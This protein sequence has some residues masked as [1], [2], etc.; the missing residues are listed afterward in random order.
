MNSTDKKNALLIKIE[1]ADNE[2]SLFSGVEKI[3]VGLSG[4][5]D[6]TC[7]LHSL[8]SLSEKYGFTLYALHVN[9]M[10]RGAE[11][12]R[13]EDFARNLCEKL[14]VTFFCERVDVPSLS[15]KT[16][17]S[18]ELCA[19][20]VRY[21]AFEKVCREHNI[22]CVATA[23]NA[24][25][26]AETMLFNLVRG[27]GT[28]GLCG[29][30]P[31][32]EL[33]Y[34]IFVVRPLIFAQR[35]EIEEYLS[36]HGQDFVTDSTN[37]DSDYTRNYLRNEIIP[38]LKKINPSLEESLQ[39]SASLHRMDEMFLSQTAEKSLTDNVDE[40]KK[41]DE[42][43]LSRVIMSMFYNCCKKTAEQKHIKELCRKIYSSDGENTNI[44]FSEGMI[45]KIYKGR[46]SFCRDERVPCRKHTQFS[47][48]LCKGLTAF[49]ETPYALYISFDEK[50][51]ISQ[52]LSFGENV[53]KK[54]TTDYL[55]F[56]TIPCVLYGRNRQDA[57]KI[58]CGRMNKSVKRLMNE[59][60][61]DESERY[62]LPFVCTKEKI[63]LVPGVAVNDDCRKAENKTHKLSVTL[64]RKA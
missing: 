42:S 7:L 11:A 40:L 41:L 43:I 22:N 23:H 51:D 63:L 15:E 32:R 6:S 62:L 8:K 24:C 37:C 57:D 21:S 3:L 39:R 38:K 26:N 13:D 61:L 58:L 16:G 49:E 47:K 5:A 45:A 12:D 1:K 56:D 52:T 27:A 53:Y 28:K 20:N 2:F 36:Y 34:G 18:V 46:L 54:Y 55:Y 10:I 19:R 17:E 29:I 33:C 9:H 48:K 64:Y 25:D 35:S 59:K 30:P 4:G 50:S 44:S 31:K 60:H 14:D